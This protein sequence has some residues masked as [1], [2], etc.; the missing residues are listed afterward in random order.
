MKNICFYFQVHQPFRLKKYR[1]FEIGN[2]HYYYNDY[3][4]EQIMHRIASRCYLP[5]NRLLLK[6]IKKYPGQFKVSFSISGTA[7]EQFKLYAPE[8]LASFKALADTG[9][10]EFLAETNAHSLAS[11]IDKKEFKKQV[12]DHSNLMETTFGQ[13]PTVFSNTGLIFSNHLAQLVAEMGF[14]TVITEGAKKILGWHSSDFIYHSAAK[15]LVNILLRDFKLCDDI[16]FRF[17]DQK[18]NEWPL[19]ASKY[20]RWIREMDQNEVVNMFLDYETFGEHQPATTG[21]F[22][23]LEEV[24]SEVQ[25][26]SDVRLV[27]PS[28]IVKDKIPQM[29]LD[30]PENI[31]RAG[32]ER[33]LSEWLGNEIQ[34]EALNKLYSLTPKIRQCN[35]PKILKDWELLQC[36]DHFRYMNT[37]F[38]SDGNE[39]ACFSPYD[40]P[41]EAFINY[42]NI[43]SD[44]IIRLDAAISDEDS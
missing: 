25:A 40:S 3:E 1:F 32:E 9:M 30:V 27:T 15:P 6:M 16:A 43:L 34:Q 29:P 5:A 23:F 42:M 17:G 2:D 35:D 33:D 13:R 22:N 44:F 11:L 20:I 26:S 39:R 7:I 10:V 19:S 28:E 37:Q 36:S 21:I 4:N 12:K 14:N 38:T 41:Y 8:V 18:W 24:I 31:S